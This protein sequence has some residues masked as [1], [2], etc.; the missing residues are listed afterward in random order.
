MGRWNLKASF[1]L[2]M[3]PSGDIFHLQAH[4]IGALVRLASF[5]ISFLAWNTTVAEHYD[6]WYFGAKDQ[7]PS[8]PRVEDPINGAPNAAVPPPQA[9]ARPVGILLGHNSSG[10]PSLSHI[11]DLSSH[12]ESVSAS[13]ARL[14]RQG[15]S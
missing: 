12:L 14:A 5:P 15:N 7:V 6:F 2:V 4:H 9:V 13:M 8:W 3:A 10:R 11:F 1:H